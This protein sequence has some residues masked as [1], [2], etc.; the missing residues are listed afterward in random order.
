MITDQYILTDELETVVA[1]VKAALG[2]SVL[3]YQYGEVEEL[4][5]TLKQLEADPAKFNLK[6]PLVWVAEPYQVKR[7]DASIFGIADV[8]VF[9]INETE[10]TWKAKERM[11]NNFKPVILPIYREFLKQIEVSTAFDHQFGRVPDHTIVNRYYL[12]ENRQS[13]LNDVVDAMKISGLKLRIHEK[14]N[15]SPFTNM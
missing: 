4:N 7:G 9:V 13:T 12:G 8:N 1:A 2:L 15:C 11:E 14:Q 6:F 3:N 10:K 5:E